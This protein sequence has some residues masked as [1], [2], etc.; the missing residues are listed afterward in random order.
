[1]NER[2]FLLFK[3]SFHS[4]K[5]PHHG[6]D[7]TVIWFRPILPVFQPHMGAEHAAF[8]SVEAH[9]FE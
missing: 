2:F 4:H 5:R 1:M 6:S 8:V 3:I 9:L 7:V